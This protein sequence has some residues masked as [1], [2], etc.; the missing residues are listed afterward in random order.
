MMQGG[1]PV[2]VGSQN[3]FISV[4]NKIVAL[5][6]NSI[7]RYSVQER[8]K[9]SEGPVA[10][11]GGGPAELVLE[12]VLAGGLDEDGR[13]ELHAGL[14]AELLPRLLPLASVNVQ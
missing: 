14:H 9:F 13:E 5:I 6:C 7:V 1:W 10:V 8:Y 11:P 3:S 4:N 12:R 2:K